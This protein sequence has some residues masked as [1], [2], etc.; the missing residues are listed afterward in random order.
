MFSSI[1]LV[2]LYEIVLAADFRC[3]T[4][5]YGYYRK[6]SFID[7]CVWTG[8][9]STEHTVF[10]F[11]T[12][13]TTTT[14]NAIQCNLISVP[15]G[16]FNKFSSLANLNLQ[17]SGISSIDTNDFRGATN[18]ISVNMSLNNIQ[19]LTKH[20]FSHAPS[21]Q[22]IDLSWNNI[23]EV[24]T[25]TFENNNAL[26]YVILNDNNIKF[27]DCILGNRIKRL[28]LQQNQLNI[29]RPN[30]TSEG[31]RIILRNNNLTSFA[32]S[33]GILNKAIGLDVSHNP[34][35]WNA[36]ITG[37][38]VLGIANTSAT[39][40]YVDQFVQILDASRNQIANVIVLHSSTLREFNLSHNKLTSISNLTSLTSLNILDIS[41]NAINDINLETFSNMT[42]LEKLNLESS[43][44]ITLDYGIFA[45]QAHLKKLDISYN[46][47]KHINLKVLSFQLQLTTIFVDGNDLTSLDISDLHQMLPNLTQIGISDNRFNC[48]YLTSLISLLTSNGIKLQIDDDVKVKNRSNVMGLSCSNNDMINWTVP[49]THLMNGTENMDTI[50]ASIR[51]SINQI[52]ESNISMNVMKGRIQ[53]LEMWAEHLSD[54]FGNEKNN[55]HS[56]ITLQEMLSV[57]NNTNVDRFA[58]ISKRFL[59]LSERLNKASEDLDNIMV[60]VNDLKTKLSTPGTSNTARPIQ[61]ALSRAENSFSKNDSVESNLVLVKTLVI[62]CFTLLLCI[63]SFLLVMVIHRY[64]GYLRH[65][66]LR[67]SNASN[68][69]IF[70]RDASSMM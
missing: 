42:E 6:S 65:K 64:R 53:A 39:H 63:V 59:N 1:V 55:T 52:D 66:Y 32:S 33:V 7:K 69:V 70:D 18:L 47:L 9:N 44:I 8:L 43:G 11:E 62:C 56:N 35:I 28:E 4:D 20:T 29:F 17:R 61:Q 48:S 34:L 46:H 49:R 19:K 50:Q 31:S 22:I 3:V 37:V 16:L 2:L 41:F 26:S 40:C 58:E 27:F 60:E 15:Y 57:I 13:P 67:S 12:N 51:D 21:L 14:I 45:H 10:N 30:S 38:T 36:T 68:A 25:E 54:F 24:S 5:E 23:T